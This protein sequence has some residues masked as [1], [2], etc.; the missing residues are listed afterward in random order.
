M[1]GGDQAPLADSFQL[2]P[3]STSGVKDLTITTNSSAES[4]HRA[5]YKF[6][7]KL[8]RTK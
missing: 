7:G 1:F 4:S 2:G 6:D 3:N 5:I 8:Y